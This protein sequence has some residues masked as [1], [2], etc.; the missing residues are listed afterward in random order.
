MEQGKERTNLPSGFRIGQLPA[1]K[2]FE[3][4]ILHRAEISTLISEPHMAGSAVSIFIV[5]AIVSLTKE[6]R[7]SVKLLRMMQTTN[8]DYS[9]I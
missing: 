4:I 9:V 2:R 6:V 8:S 5:A 3:A 7:R 1:R